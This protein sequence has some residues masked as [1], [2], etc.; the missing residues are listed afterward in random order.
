M[1]TELG[2]IPDSYRKFIYDFFPNAQ[3]IVDKF[4][5]IRLLSPALL[6]ERKKITGKNADRRARALLL[7]SSKKLS[8]LDRLTIHRYLERYPRLKELYRW[9]E[10]VHS[11]Y[12]TKG[13]DRA[14]RVL[15][16]LVIESL[17]AAYSK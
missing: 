17:S 12:R 6:K 8:Y 10:S 3:I 5:V 11:F 1:S 2:K 14:K 7:C 16:R 13:Y 4:H 9:K 15:D